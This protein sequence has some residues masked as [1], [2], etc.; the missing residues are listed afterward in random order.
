M[1]RVSATTEGVPTSRM[2]DYYREFARGGFRLVITEG[3]YPDHDAS[4]G[5]DNQPG[6][7]DETQREA[8]ARVAAAVHEDGGHI[9][10]QLMHAGALSQRTLN[11]GRTIAPSRI[12]PRGEM[13]P[14][15]GGS[16]AYPTPD[17][18]TTDDLV[19]VRDGFAAAAVRAQDAGFD[20]VE[21]HAANGYLLDQFITVYTNTRSDEYGGDATGRIRY[22]SE[23]VAAIR[24]ATDGAFIV[25]VR[26]SEAK[27]NDFTYR[28]PG[29]PAEAQTIFE[30]LS[31]AG[32]S[33]LHLAGEGRGFREALEKAAE[34]YGT[35]ARR[36][37]GMPIVVNGGLH[38]PDL[39]DAAVAGGHGDLIGIG[40]SALANPDWPRRV[41]AGASLDAFDPAM[42]S[43]RATIK[44]SDR[45]WGDRIERGS[46][47]LLDSC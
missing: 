38:D 35:L 19:V 11:G 20:G 3:T 25:G 43:P 26:V 1:T 18:M 36:L 12:Q 17:E 23:V 27:V 28:W 15:Y 14:E 24:A 7:A 5:Y 8:W 44:N 6:I 42:L 45:W 32:A 39:A 10:L 37:T 40:R 16:G 47:R 29:G 33:Y 21:V 9:L 34:S 41:G 2:V 30:K 22:P 13:M 46:R 4:R 31:E